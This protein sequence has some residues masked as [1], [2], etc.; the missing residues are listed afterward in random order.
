M[1]V[2]THMQFNDIDADEFIE[3]KEILQ[4]M[5]KARDAN[6]SVLVQYGKVLFCGVAGAGKSNFL[7]LLMKNP[8]ESSHIST[9]MFKPQQVAMKVQVSSNNS[10]EVEFEKMNI[11]DE[12][13]NL[14]S[15]L[16][17]K[18]TTTT[19]TTATTASANTFASSSKSSATF[20]NEKYDAA[21]ENFALA[22]V[23]IKAKKVPKKDHGEV[24]NILT[25]MDTGGQ[26]QFI[27]MLPVVNSFAMITLILLFTK[28]QQVVKHLLIK[29]P[30][31]HMEMKMVKFL[32]YHIHIIIP[33]FSLLK[34]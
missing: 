33:T 23:D 34:H 2:G 13:L 24:W 6:Y 28:L 11:D 20:S 3:K 14:Y 17:D 18:Y 30:K 12:I 29:L 10:T 32:L 31:F 25:F 16:P 19:T 1:Y 5:L 22:N 15:Y 26:P 21:A 9:A 8:F 4:S 27:S 7:N